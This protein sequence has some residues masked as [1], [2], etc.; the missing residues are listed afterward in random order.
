MIKATQRFG[1]IKVLPRSERIRVTRSRSAVGSYPDDIEF[2]VC[3]RFKSYRIYLDLLIFEFTNCFEP[4]PEWVIQS[5]NAFDF[6]NDLVFEERIECF[7]KLLEIPFGIN[8][9][10]SEEKQRLKF[11]YTTLHLNALNVVSTSKWVMVM[12]CAINGKGY[13]NNCRFVNRFAIQFLNR[14][15]NEC[16]VESEIAAFVQIAAAI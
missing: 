9:L 7:A 6:L 2:I 12:V 11:E 1:N 15:F 14:S 8:P 13:Y 10:L 16:V 5:K 4:W 3:E